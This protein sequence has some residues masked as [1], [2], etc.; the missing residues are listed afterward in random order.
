MGRTV[1]CEVR[2]HGGKA[3][4]SVDLRVSISASPLKTSTVLMQGKN[5]INPARKLKKPN[6]GLDETRFIRNDEL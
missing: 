4:G 1:D 3:D 5:K 6:D 2:L